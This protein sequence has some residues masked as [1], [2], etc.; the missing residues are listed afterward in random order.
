MCEYHIVVRILH[1]N[2]VVE[3]SLSSH[4]RSPK[5]FSCRWIAIYRGVDFMD[6]VDSLVHGVVLNDGPQRVFRM[7]LRADFTVLSVVIGL[8]CG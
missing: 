7:L 6:F 3:P 2:T 8:T 1:G 5:K 4:P